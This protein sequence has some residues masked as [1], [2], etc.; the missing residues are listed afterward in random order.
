MRYGICGGLP[1]S[2]WAP[3]GKALYITAWK[4]YGACENHF[5]LRWRGHVAPYNRDLSHPKEP[6][7]TWLGSIREAFETSSSPGN[8]GDSLVSIWPL[9]SDAEFR[10]LVTD[11]GIS[12]KVWPLYSAL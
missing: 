8:K 6:F 2:E 5:D 7:P 1:D 3:G 12:A 10:K 4:D 11:V 9:D